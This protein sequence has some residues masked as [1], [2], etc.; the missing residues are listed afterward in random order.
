MKDTRIALVIQNSI[1]GN[2][3]ENLHSSIRFIEKAGKQNV[4]IIVFPEMNLTGYDS[5]KTVH[6][7]A[8]PLDSKLLRILSDLSLKYHIG[9][10]AGMARKHENNV[11]ASH[12]V[13]LP[14]GTVDLYDKIHTAPFEKK[15]FSQGDLP[16]VFNSKTLCFGIQLCYDAHFPSLSTFMALR[17]CEMI[18]IPHASPK[19]TS[20]EKF[21]SWMRHLTARAFDNGIFI[22]ACNQVGDNQNGLNFPGIA[23]V[24]GPDGKVLSKKLSDTEKM[25]TIQI[26]KHQLALVRNHKM[27]YFLPNRRNDLALG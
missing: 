2:F 19:G 9:I 20:K 5:G 15:Y 21:E 13:V 11:F 23:V 7:I 8:R 24:I 10:L 16:R 14:D 18:F 27:R 6:K 3:E 12:L 4:D 26:T 25:L 17:G 1:A 22:S